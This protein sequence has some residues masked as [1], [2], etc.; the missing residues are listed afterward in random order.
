MTVI[1]NLSQE[2]PEDCF[3]CGGS[4]VEESDA[5]E[6]AIKYLESNGYEVR[7]NEIK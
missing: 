3:V 7:K 4:G 5:M 2:S 1:A 6:Q